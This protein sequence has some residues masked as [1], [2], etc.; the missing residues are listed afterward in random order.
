MIELYMLERER[1]QARA[2]RAGR[3]QTE[4]RRRRRAEQLDRPTIR[5]SVSRLRGLIA[6]ASRRAAPGRS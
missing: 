2:T 4:L 3:W 6:G 1:E 5:G